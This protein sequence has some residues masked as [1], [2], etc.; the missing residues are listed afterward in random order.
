MDRRFD[1]PGAAHLVL[2]EYVLPLDPERR[3][4]EAMLG[5]DC[6]PPAA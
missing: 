3:V 1:L 4:F 6:Q 5:A 2:V